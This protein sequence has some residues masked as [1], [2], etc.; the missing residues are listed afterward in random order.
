MIF[1]AHYAHEY[2]DDGEAHRIHHEISAILRIESSKFGVWRWVVAIGLHFLPL[3]FRFD[4]HDMNSVQVG[5][6]VETR[7]RNARL[8]FDN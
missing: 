6:W 3:V 2:S 7:K 4:E 5:V 8:L 1:P